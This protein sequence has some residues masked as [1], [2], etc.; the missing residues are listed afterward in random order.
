MLDLCGFAG[1]FGLETGL[2]EKS[3][4]LQVFGMFVSKPLAG[5]DSTFSAQVDNSLI[6]Q[7]NGAA[8]KTAAPARSYSGLEPGSATPSICRSAAGVLTCTGLSDLR[9]SRSPVAIYSA[10]ALA[11]HTAKTASS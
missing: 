3:G 4:V 1:F 7:E 11:A 5:D 6:L 9:N 2:T 10:P 8:I